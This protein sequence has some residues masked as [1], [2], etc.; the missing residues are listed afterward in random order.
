MKFLKVL[1]P[2]DE[3]C[4]WKSNNGNWFSKRS[5]LKYNWNTFKFNLHSQWFSDT[6]LLLRSICLWEVVVFWKIVN[7]LLKIVDKVLYIE[8]QT[9]AF[10][11]YFGFTNIGSEINSF[12]S[13]ALYFWQFSFKTWYQIDVMFSLCYLYYSCCWLNCRDQGLSVW[14]LYADTCSSA[15]L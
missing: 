13:T 11:T 7:K 10:Q 6:L 9:A 8:K 14:R 12:S 2:I 4:L 1:E 3:Y 5:F 15:C